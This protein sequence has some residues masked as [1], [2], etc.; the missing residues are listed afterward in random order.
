MFDILAPWF[1]FPSLLHSQ[2][3]HTETELDI[4]ASYTRPRFAHT[5]HLAFCNK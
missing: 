3:V 5:I 1:Q 2:H 4:R